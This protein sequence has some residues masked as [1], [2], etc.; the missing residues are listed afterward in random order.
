MEPLALGSRASGHSRRSSPTC[1]AG[2]RAPPRADETQQWTS[3]VVMGLGDQTGER[4]LRIRAR[5]P[6]GSV[7]GAASYVNGLSAQGANRGLPAL[8]SP[9][10]APASDTNDA[11]HA[12]GHDHH[13]PRAHHSH[14]GMSNEERKLRCFRG[15][16]GR[17]DAR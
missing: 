4:H 5:S 8:R 10:K 14:T 13:D 3:R 2:R 6:T 7:A 1:L 17:L 15:V 16:H 11:K 9:T 12:T